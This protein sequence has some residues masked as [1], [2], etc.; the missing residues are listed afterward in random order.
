MELLGDSNPSVVCNSLAALNE[1]RV[2][3]SN[4]P[5][6]IDSGTANKLMAALPECN[7][8]GQVD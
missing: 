3:I 5:Y 7:E 1:I 8:W 4:K 6:V 2:S